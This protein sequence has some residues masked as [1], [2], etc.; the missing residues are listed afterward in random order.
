MGVL[1][2]REPLDFPRSWLLIVMREYVRGAQLLYYVEHLLPLT[3]Q[4]RTHAQQWREKGKEREAMLFDTL[5]S[6]VYVRLAPFCHHHFS[7]FS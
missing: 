4:M 7:L 6:Q 1:S 5:E 2:F 3:G